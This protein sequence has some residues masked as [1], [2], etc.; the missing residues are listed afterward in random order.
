M[1]ASVAEIAYAYSRRRYTGAPIAC[2][3]TS[4]SRTP[5]SATPNGEWTIVRTS[6]HPT[7][8]TT[9]QYRKAVFPNMSNRNIPRIGWIGTLCSPSAPPVT[10]VHLFAISNTIEAIASVS[11]KSARPCVRRITAPVASPSSPAATAATTS[12]S[13]GSP[14]TR[15][16]KTPAAY[17]PKPK[18]AAWPS[19]TMPP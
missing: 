10:S 5:V 13:S 2:M 8:S 17:A 14:L 15:I 7:A 12:P 19:V 6:H 1:P 4:F 18:Y 16:A 9:R 3:R 11:I